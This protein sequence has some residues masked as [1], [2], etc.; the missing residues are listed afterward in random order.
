MLQIW[1]GT[2]IVVVEECFLTFHWNWNVLMTWPIQ[3]VL[4]EGPNLCAQ[5][6][7]KGI[8]TNCVDTAGLVGRSR[9]CKSL[10]LQRLV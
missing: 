7:K 8:L 6:G 9:C 4:K 2:S 10:V 5:E 3:S 1:L